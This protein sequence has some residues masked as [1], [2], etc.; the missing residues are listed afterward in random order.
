[1]VPVIHTEKFQ[2]WDIISSKK[3]ELEMQKKQNNIAL[4]K[5]RKLLLKQLKVSQL[6]LKLAVNMAFM[7]LRLPGGSK[8]Q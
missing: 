7:L 5:K 4:R 8:K 6:L 1:M 2:E 3:K